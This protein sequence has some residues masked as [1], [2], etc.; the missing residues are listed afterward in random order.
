[1]DRFCGAN[2]ISVVLQ[3]NGA[4]DIGAILLASLEKL[5]HSYEG[6]VPMSLTPS[7]YLQKKLKKLIS[8][9]NSYK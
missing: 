5:S 8:I 3:R 4:D 1:M 6:V 2:I 7:T 9:K